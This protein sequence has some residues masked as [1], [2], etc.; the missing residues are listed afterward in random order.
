[1]CTP[2]ILTRIGDS[3][4][5]NTWKDSTSTTLN[6]ISSNGASG[7]LPPT[8]VEQSTL[9]TAE[10]DIFATTACIQQQMT[11][12]GSTTNAI[13]EAQSDILRLTQQISKKEVDIQV[14]KDRVA[15]IRHPEAH[16]SFYESWFP[17]GRPMH[18]AGIPYFIGLSVALILFTIFVLLSVMGINITVAANP[19]SP[20]LGWI[21]SQVTPFAVIC[22]IALIS[23]VIYFMTRK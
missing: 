15:Y 13:Q 8:P 2:T 6:S 12:L 1:M 14:A 3:T 5:F 19:T 22:L 20:M 16:T 17:M 10:S 23:V 4:R 7:N 21:L 9:V 18:T 11:T